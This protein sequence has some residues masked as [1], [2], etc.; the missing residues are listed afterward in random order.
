MPEQTPFAIPGGTIRP[1]L[2]KVLA[3]L[4]GGRPRT[5]NNV[6]LI[7]PPDDP[8]DIP[9]ICTLRAVTQ[10]SF[11]HRHRRCT[12]IANSSFFPVG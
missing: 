12:S 6:S 5:F 1:M 4:A 11:E 3:A 2:L 9:Q 7:V 8:Y 10:E